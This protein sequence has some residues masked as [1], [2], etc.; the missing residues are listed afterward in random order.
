MILK[1]FI[2]LSIFYSSNYLFYGCT[3]TQKYDAVDKITKSNNRKEVYLDYI[4][5]LIGFFNDNYVSFFV[6][7]KGNEYEIYFSVN[8]LHNIAIFLNEHDNLSDNQGYFLDILDKQRLIFDQMS[9]QEN[10]NPAFSSFKEEDDNFEGKD[11][12]DKNKLIKNKLEVSN[13][14]EEQMRTYVV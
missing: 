11:L 4:K 9:E 3:E 7:L 10:I 12:F 6:S 8:D 14:Q 2:L 13:I 1:L 5:S